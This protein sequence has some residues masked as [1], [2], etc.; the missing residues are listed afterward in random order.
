VLRLGE[1]HKE[2][3]VQKQEN[4]VDAAN[5]REHS[6][7]QDTPRTFKQAMRSAE[8]KQRRSAI[9]KELANLKRKSVWSVKRLPKQRRA[10]GARWVFARKE[11]P[12]GSTRYKARYV[13]KGFNQKEGTDFAHTFAPTATF[14]SVRVLLTIAAKHNWPVY[15]FDF[16]AAYLNA[17]IDKEVW[18]SPP[19]GLN[20]QEGDACLL[21]KVLYGTKQAARCWWK[22]LSS[23][24]A[25]L[26]YE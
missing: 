6:D 24:L 2:E 13:A 5:D 22:R 1:F 14:T 7:S 21:H 18:V 20:S 4:N 16:V 26:G 23:S 15:N 19:E 10:L 12:D 17:P 3:I 8:S 9:D 25:S 11:N